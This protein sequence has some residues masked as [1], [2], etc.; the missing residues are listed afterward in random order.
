MNIYFSKGGIKM[1]TKH[2]KE[3]STSLVIRDMKFKTTMRYHLTPIS[4]DISVHEKTWKKRKI[5]ITN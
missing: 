5:H 1:A 3:F 2:M 4:M